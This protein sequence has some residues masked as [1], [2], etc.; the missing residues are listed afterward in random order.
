MGKTKISWTDYTWNPVWG[1]YGGCDYCYARGIAKRFA[2]PIAQ[3]EGDYFNEYLEEE[4][5]FIRDFKPSLLMHR[6]DIQFPKNAKRIFVNS[7]SDLAFWHKAWILMVIDKIKKNPDKIFQILTKFPEQLTGYEFP[8]N[9][10]IGITAEN[11]KNLS[12]R[13]P[14][15]SKIKAGKHFISFEPLQEKINVKMLNWHNNSFYQILEPI[16]NCGDSNRI[17][18]DWFIIGCQTGI[19]RVKIDNQL[20]FDL[21]YQI[22][23]NSKIPIFVK[24]MEI[25]GVIV[26]ENLPDEYN[27]REFPISATNKNRFVN[28]KEAY[29]IAFNANQI[30]V[31]NK[32]YPINSIGL[33]SE[34]LY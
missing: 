32:G 27:Y 9:V 24:Q 29:Q 17:A 33:T 20:I 23:N 34:Y 4:F 30:I 3:R 14:A 25:D 8:D 1:C 7:M 11:Q 26:K 10:W 2:K 5:E 12:E 16:T 21:I 31:P 13:F 28:R 22:K 19:N 6:F 18:P 15:F